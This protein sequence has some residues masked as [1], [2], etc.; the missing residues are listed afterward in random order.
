MIAVVQRVL[1]SSVVING[2]LYS[3]IEKGVNIL[4]GFEKGDTVENITRM[5]KKCSELRIFEDENGKMSNSIIDIDGE[6]LIV[7]QFT[8][9]G[10]VSKG[11]RPDFT[12]AM[13]P[14]LAKEYY[15]KFI[16]ECKKIIGDDKVK[17]GIFAADMKVSILNDGPVTIIIKL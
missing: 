15:E 14:D 10:D 11:R 17:S 2:S 7:S 9:A 5:A 13:H 4:I 6:M 16:C 12:N 3:Q 1:Q 8:L